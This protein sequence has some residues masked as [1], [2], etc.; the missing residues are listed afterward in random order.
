MTYRECYEQG[1]HVLQA[2][3]VPEFALD[4]RLLL[5]FVCNTNRNDLLVHGDAEVTAGQAQIYE[6]LIRKREQRIPLQQIT[7]QQEFMGLTFGVNENVLI[8]RQDTE[9]LVEEILPFLSSGVRILDMC[10]GSG[11]ILISLLQIHSGR[12]AWALICRRWHYR[13]QKKMPQLS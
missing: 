8:P 11:C 12:R 3:G 1:K 7:G 2:A 4:A 13:W 10:T 9:I 5:E 6:A